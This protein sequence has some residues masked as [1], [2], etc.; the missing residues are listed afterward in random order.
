MARLEA[1]SCYRVCNT[2]YAYTYIHMYVYVYPVFT[3]LYLYI[4]TYVCMY[5]CMYRGV[6]SEKYRHFE[7]KH[8]INH[9]TTHE[10][11]V[12]QLKE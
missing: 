2:C 11:I 5:V 8:V 1:K 12:A 7:D 10:Y 4:H 3:P 6:S 9:K